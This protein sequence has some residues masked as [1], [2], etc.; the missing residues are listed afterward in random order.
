MPIPIGCK[1]CSLNHYDPVTLIKTGE[2]MKSMYGYFIVDGFLRNIIPMYKNPFNKP[3]IV[4]NNFYEQMSR[5]EILYTKGYEYENSYHMVGAMVVP[6][7]A[8]TGRGGAAVSPPDF[9]FSLQFNHKSMYSENTFNAG[10]KRSKKLYNAVPIKFLFCAFGCLTDE[11]MIHYICPEMND[12]SLINAISYACLQ[13][14]KHREAVQKA[15]L[16]IK[17]NSNYIIYD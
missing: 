15:N 13:G 6:K 4:K 16:K 3:I 14:Y 5:T 1:W 12:F 2:E 11:E 7:S 10:P 8:H 9:I 17:S